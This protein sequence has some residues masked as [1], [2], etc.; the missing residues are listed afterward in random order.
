M[1]GIRAPQGLD[2]EDRIALGLG[3]THL[4]YLVMF[5]MSGWAILSSSL[6]LLLRGPLGVLVVG[7]GVLLAWGRVGGRPLDR[8][9]VLYARY[10][11]RPRASV[12][13]L[14]AASAVD[15]AVTPIPVVERAQA[16]VSARIAPTAG[17][18]RARRVAF[19]SQ[20]GGSGK[21]ALAFETATLLSVLSGARVVVLDLDCVSSTMRVRSGLDGLGMSDL[22]EVPQLDAPEL[23]G[24]LLRHPGGTRVVL[25]A[26]ALPS[27]ERFMECAVALLDHL[28]AAGYEVVVMDLGTAMLEDATGLAQELVERLDA[29]YCVFTPTPGSVFGLYR[30]VAALRRNGLRGRVRLVLNRHD[31]PISLDEI[32]GDL[33][34]DVLASLPTMEAIRTAERTHV[35]ACMDDEVVADALYPLAEDI[36]PDM[37]ARWFDRAGRRAQAAAGLP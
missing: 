35:P 16:A 37:S 5:S 17:G 1:E 23:E 32:V 3:A 9:V 12:V 29:I 25:G 2:A 31:T 33:R 15:A 13:R 19:Y 27:P 20:S 24:V 4:F 26:A 18:R 11:A 36:F 7:A 6:P 30:A 8:W 14:S 10:R 34:V 21:T 22:M 28:D